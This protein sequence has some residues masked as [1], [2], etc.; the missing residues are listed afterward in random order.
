MFRKLVVVGLVCFVGLGNVF[1]G[2]VGSRVKK[3]EAKSAKSGPV[4]T[5]SGIKFV[6]KCKAE[7][8]F[9]AGSFND[10]ST[11]KNPL[12][13]VK[14]DVWEI[15]FPL[16]A[17][18]YQY[19]FVVDGNWFTDPENPNTTDDGLGGKNS[20]LEVTAQA[21]K[22]VQTRADKSSAPFPVKGGY[23]FTFYA[24]TSD[25]VYLAGSFNNWA[26][27]KEGVI[28]NPQYLM[29]KNPQ[30]I[31]MM[32]VPLSSG[33]YQYKYCVN[34]KTGDW[35]ADKP[36]GWTADPNNNKNLDKDGNSILMVK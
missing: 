9:V 20:V 26:D 28:D 19:K 12:K 33:K 14:K 29:K 10:W 8:V 5:K 11:T 1:A 6:Y 34:G 4:E 15:V 3:E 18:K 35:T 16:D 32:V 23:K 36:D 25:A 21:K 24:P 17:G 27:N 2:K 7:N 13:Q 30:G 31:W 22:T